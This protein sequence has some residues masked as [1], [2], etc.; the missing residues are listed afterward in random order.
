V[1]SLEAFEA[2]HAEQ[3]LIWERQALLRARCLAGDEGLATR[4]QE[5]VQRIVYERPFSD[6]MIPEIHHLR[7]RMRHELA[8]E[9]KG[10]HNVKLGKGGLVEILFIVQLLQLQFGR[11]HR[12]LRTPNTVDAL[13]QLRTDDL[14]TDGVYQI[15]ISATH[16][17]RHLENGLRLIHDR[18]LNEFREEPEE[19][20]ELARHL[21]RGDVRPEEGAQRLLQEFLGHTEAV[22]EIYCHFFH[23][24]D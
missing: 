6:E 9:H 18:S 3:G 22:R 20:G 12:S 21:Y 7:E 15:L 23:T 14:L 4:V 17:L 5:V 8:R 10:R 13:T 24:T 1:T 11:T 19:L 16:F 2:Y